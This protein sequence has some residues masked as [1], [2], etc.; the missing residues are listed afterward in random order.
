MRAS[1]HI[2]LAAFAGLCVAMCPNWGW[3]QVPTLSGTAPL[4]AKP[5][6]TVQVRVRGGNLIDPTEFWT[7][8]TADKV[9]AADIPNNGKNA[10]ELVYNITL[11]ADAPVGVQGIRVATAAGV[12]NLLLF[13]L[14]DLPSIAQVKPNTTPETAQGITLPCA[15]DGNVDSL[16]RN[17]YKFAVQAG[18]RVA[19]EVLGRRIGSPLD[20]MVRIMD[21]QGRELAYSDDA[22]GLGGDSQLCYTF[23]NAGEYLLELR[24]VRFQGGGNFNYRLRI[25]DFP[26]VNVPYPMGAKRGSPATITFAGTHV[27][28]LAP[29]SV[30]VPADDTLNWLSVGAKAAGGQ[31]SGFANLSLG[32]GNEAV[33]QEPNDLPAA[34]TRVELGANLNGR[35]EKPGDVDH[36]VFTAKAGQRFNFVGITRQQGAPTDLYLRM[37]KADGAQIAAADDTGTT[38]GVLDFN[39]PADGDYTLAVEDLHR[40][41]GSQFAYRVAVQPYQVGFEL[42]AA[43]DTLNLPQEGTVAVAVTA[44]RGGH[45]GPIELSL[46]N[47]PPGVTATPTV[48]GPGVNSAVLTLESAG[49][50][51]AGQ[52][53]PVKIVGKAR[54]GDVEFQAVAS[55]TAA[56]RT[57]LAAMPLP[58][59][60]LGGSLALAANPKPFY[61]LRSEPK[62]LVFGRSI[63]GTVKVSAIRA[64]DF[65]EAITLA[66]NPPQNG[67]PPG[68]TAAVKPIDKDK[69]EVEI[70]FTATPQAP[71]GQFSIV[72]QGTGKKGND[73]VIQAVPA[74][75][76]DLQVPFTLTTEFG[77]AKLV[78]GGT[79]KV[80]VKAVR[81]PAYPGPIVLTW[82]NLPKGV[83][84]ADSTIAEGQTEAEVVLTAA[85]DATVGAVENI[86]VK[87]EGT[88]NNVKF[89][90]SAPNAKL[91]VE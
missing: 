67:L 8:F 54:I 82:T 73:T 27:E 41:G 68:I 19:F 51:P 91:T 21:L 36:F 70:V 56:Q 37:L 26:C 87:G 53:F 55:L 7:S 75:R 62:T 11:P 65:P 2:G 30:N 57:A 63:N 77:D 20:P 69:N 47:P 79:L 64:A 60:G 24:D 81:N 23:A 3:T 38:E 89:A 16:V 12:S 78:K 49:N 80:K 58:P 33:E 45:N 61:V 9:L 71:L 5:G 76:L 44:V 42:S 88:S 66:V 15:V 22:P 32:S 50:V 25:G 43:T 28:G 29:I 72:L 83:T 48:I 34:A 86:S 52:I 14:D 85:A 18:Q 13:V 59:P 84:A 39:C 40:R 74:I 35:F 4:A 1:P 90:E 6:A 46:L 10:G 17:Y 31:S